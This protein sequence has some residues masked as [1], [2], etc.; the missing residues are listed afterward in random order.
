MKKNRQ[1]NRQILID[2]LILARPFSDIGADHGITR[3]RALQI[4]HQE[5]RR[6][7]RQAAEHLVPQGINKIRE[8][9]DLFIHD[10]STLQGAARQT[11]QLITR[12]PL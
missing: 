8:H 4:F 6:R 11:Y 10:A 7:N 2:A 5:L 12:S 9:P 3:Q 1:R